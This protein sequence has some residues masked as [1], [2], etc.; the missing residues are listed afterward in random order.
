MSR[1]G[2]FL[3]NLDRQSKSTLWVITIGFLLGVG[4]I[5]YLTGFEI[6]FAFFYSIPVSLASWTLGRNAGLGIAVAGAVV[7]QFAN[8]LAG[9][10]FSSPWINLWNTITRLGFFLVISSLLTEIHTLLKNE[11]VLSRTDPLTGILNRRAFFESASLEL[12]RLHKRLQPLTIIYLDLDE[13]KRVNDTLGH[14]VG[15]RLLRKVADL[16]TLQLRGMDIVSRV[17]GDEFALLLPETDQE[18]SHHV[19]Q[20]LFH[21]L[22][23]AMQLENW[24]LTFSMGVLTCN[25]PPA[26]VDELL[27]RADQLMYAAKKEGRNSVHYGTYP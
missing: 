17:G 20:R 22:Q 11:S 5:D 19:I 6:S 13:F 14:H 21:A 2:R 1:T 24:P 9:E 7:W 16:L 23:E 8:L 27:H 4:L 18:A 26:S 12:Q 10:H 15:D 25:S 3:A